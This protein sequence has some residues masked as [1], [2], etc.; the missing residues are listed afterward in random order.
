MC[1]VTKLGWLS[2]LERKLEGW[3]EQL[4]LLFFSTSVVAA[5]KTEV[6]TGK[7]NALCHARQEQFWHRILIIF[8]GSTKIWEW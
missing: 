8:N 1:L 2:K 3:L 7:E 4:R 6:V 5:N